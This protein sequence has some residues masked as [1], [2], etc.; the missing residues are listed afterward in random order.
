MIRVTTI[1]AMLWFCFTLLLV[2]SFPLQVYTGSPYPSLLPYGLVGLIFLFTMLGRRKGVELGMASSHSRNISLMVRIYVY[3]LIGTTV[4]LTGLG[5]ISSGAALSALVIHLLPVIVF[6][7]F[8]RLGSEREIR[9]VLLAMV[10][11]GVIVG[12]FFAY[13]SYSKLATGQVSEF[14]IKAFEYSIER[15]NQ[16]AADANMSRIRTGYRSSGLLQHHSVSGAWIVLGA[17]ASLALLA[18]SSRFVRRGVVL[19]F[20]TML[21]LGLNFTSIIV[22][23]V[24]MF[25]FEFGGAALLR[26]RPPAIFGNLASL[27]VLVAVVAGAALWLAGDTMGQFMLNLFLGQRDFAL[28]IGADS[29]SKISQMLAGLNTY[30]QHI[31]NFPLSLLIGDG[32]STFGSSKGGDVGFVYSMATFGLPFYLAIVYGL[33]RLIRLGFRRMRAMAGRD[34]DGVVLNQR[35]ILQFSICV[36]MLVLIAEA[37][38]SIWAAKAILPI[39]FFALAL[40]GRYLP[41]PVP[42]HPGPNLTR[43]V[44]MALDAPEPMVGK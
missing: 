21:L 10:L 24:T 16:S 44:V 43:R 38:Y 8:R 32:F 11:A 22:F 39:M 17:F 1:K 30:V 41:A 40:F 37:H 42:G 7:Y 4:W 12:V 31:L 33:V 26:S 28:G 36:M 14:S 15:S 5:K 6:R 9:A 13:D 34:Q 23:L 18:P 2:L 27:A 3:L 25:L 19:T 20:G 35:G 29:P